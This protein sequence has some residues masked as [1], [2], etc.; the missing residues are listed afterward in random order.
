MERSDRQL[1]MRPH[2]YGNGCVKH[3]RTKTDP[4][5]AAWCAVHG[6]WAPLKHG[7]YHSIVQGVADAFG[8]KM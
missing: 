5:M 1:R 7:S 8:L 4:K 3:D 6:Y 2:G